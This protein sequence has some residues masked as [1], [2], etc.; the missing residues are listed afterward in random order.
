VEWNE[1]GYVWPQITS[2]T[3][4]R[5]LTGNPENYTNVH[6]NG[7]GF[8]PS[9]RQLR[10][11][12]GPTTSAKPPEQVLLLGQVSCSDLVHVSDTLLLC[13]VVRAPTSAAVSVTVSGLSATVSMLQ[14]ATRPSVDTATLTAGTGAPVDGGFGVT[15][16][17]SF[18]WKPADVLEVNIG[19]RTTPSWTWISPSVIQA[20][21]PPGFGQSAAVEVK[22]TN[23]QSSGT[24]VFISY[25]VA[26]VHRM[27][28]DVLLPNVGNI[29]VQIL[30]RNLP[31]DASML[32]SI[33][34][35]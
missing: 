25:D 24:A 18:G 35:A 31:P 3:P 12:L 19:G 26:Q 30:G 4:S 32:G 28:P 29:T 7:T 5:F 22:L 2:V 27:V 17:G 15:L 9:M 33:R 34:V 23:G 20:V 14:L 13:R 8:G 11:R 1:F 16:R 21:A 10:E 6:I